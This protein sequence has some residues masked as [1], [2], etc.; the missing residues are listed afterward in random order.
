MGSART[1]LFITVQCPPHN[2]TEEC[3]QIKNNT[4]DD[5]DAGDDE[6]IDVIH[7]ITDTSKLETWGRWIVIVPE[8]YDS[9]QQAGFGNFGYSFGE[10]LSQAC[11]C[12]FQIT[13]TSETS[14]GNTR[15]DIRVVGAE[16]SVN[17]FEEVTN[18]FLGFL[19]NND[20]L[21]DYDTYS[22]IVRLTED[23]G[24]LIW[25]SGPDPD[26]TTYVF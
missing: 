8:A 4:G 22:F 2:T 1:V 14:D 6:V 24:R 19:Q 25:P 13:L 3:E 17:N 15:L 9:V 16:D 10:H 5:D 12:D 23:N 18:N 7:N 26:A 20:D 21:A 11:Q